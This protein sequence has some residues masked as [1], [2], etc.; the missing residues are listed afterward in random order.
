MLTYVLHCC[1]E[2]FQRET[3]RKKRLHAWV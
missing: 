2:L 3:Q 1:R